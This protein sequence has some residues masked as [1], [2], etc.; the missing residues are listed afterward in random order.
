[1]NCVQY[2]SSRRYFIRD[3]IL[4]RTECLRIAKDIKVANNNRE[5]SPREI[6]YIFMSYRAKSNLTS[7][8]TAYCESVFSAEHE[9]VIS[10]LKRMS[11]AREQE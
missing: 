8:R 9:F 6:F 10:S 3:S 11:F 1:M 2:E 5:R 7:Y 4:S